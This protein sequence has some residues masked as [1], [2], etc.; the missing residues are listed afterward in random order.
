MQNNNPKG[1]ESR[2]SILPKGDVTSIGFLGPD[3]NA[4]DELLMPHMIGVRDQGTMG[5]TI[6]AVKGVA[7]YVD[8]IGFGAPSN[9]LT[10]SMRNKP[11]PLGINYFLK[12][13]QKCS[14]GANMWMYVNGI[15]KGDA[16]GERTRFAMEKV[17]MP[18]LKG[19]APGIIEDTRD[20]LNPKPFINSL[21]GSGYPECEQA[22]FSVG[23]STGKIYK[24]NLDGSQG[25]P[26]IDDPQSAIRQGNKWVQT[27]WIQKTAKEKTPNGLI[28]ET[29]VY[30]DRDIWVST[31]KTHNPD[32]TL[33]SDKSLTLIKEE[34][35]PEISNLRPNLDSIN[36]GE[37]FTNQN[38]LLITAATATILSS[39]LLYLIAKK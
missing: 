13:G 25:E 37:E 3:Y 11:E 36:A 1:N 22:T 6:D 19:L 2:N 23:T 34:F 24:E 17:G 27:K 29:P 16:L 32:G 39:V 14:N 35:R 30:L 18:P 7:Y 15:P 21:F 4:A 26:L 12:T 38:S 9:P 31:P 8:M 28:K 10:R 5:A 20:A 33:K